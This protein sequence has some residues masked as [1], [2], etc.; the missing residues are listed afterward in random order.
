MIS[1]NKKVA[2][3][4]FKKKTLFSP[5]SSSPLLCSPF[6][7]PPL[8]SSPLLSSP[9]PSPPLP[10]SPLLSSPLPS[11]PLLLFHSTEQHNPERIQTSPKRAFT[12]MSCQLPNPPLQEQLRHVH[13]ESHVLLHN[14]YKHDGSYTA[15]IWS[16]VIYNYQL[17]TMHRISCS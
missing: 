5:F 1:H 14:E 16:L 12:A 15:H 4:S 17:P 2:I 10:S 6:L 11:P 3:A 7:S 8:L 9:L 13:S